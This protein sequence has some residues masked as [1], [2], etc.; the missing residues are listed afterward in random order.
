MTSAYSSHAKNE[1]IYFRR[2]TRYDRL[3]RTT[4]KFDAFHDFHKRYVLVKSYYAIRCDN[5]I[6]FYVDKFS[7]TYA[8]HLPPAGIEYESCD[9]ALRKYKRFDDDHQRVEIPN[10][11]IMFSH[12]LFIVHRENFVYTFASYYLIAMSLEL[13]NDDVLFTYVEALSQLFNE[14]AG[15]D[16]F[17][18]YAIREIKA[19]EKIRK[20]ALMA[21]YAKNMLQ[22]TQQTSEIVEKTI[23][24]LNRVIKMVDV[25]KLIIL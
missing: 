3:D 4:E 2:G 12:D 20:P 6:Y 24:L 23:E 13:L 16:R 8:K 14:W 22:T 5:Y 25:Y 21:K 15:S 10:D 19:G 17:T 1:T 11:A 9:D 7:A 18:D